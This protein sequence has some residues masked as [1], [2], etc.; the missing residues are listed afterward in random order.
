MDIKNIDNENINKP[1]LED[2]SEKT[3]EIKS[4]PYKKRKY[5]FSVAELK[6]FEILKEVIRDN[7]YIFPK[8]R[9]CDIVNSENKNKYSQFNKIKSKHVDFLVCTKDPIVS[10]MI[11]ELDDSSHNSKS[12]IERDTFIDE[13]FANSR[14]PIVHINVKKF[15]NKK[16]LK[17]EIQ[18]AYKTKYV[19]KE[20]NNSS[21]RESCSFLLIFILLIPFIFLFT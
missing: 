17:K 14:I 20:G 18:D 10:K 2:V 16:L 12:R 15:Y 5:F 9:I 7:Y 21:N 8:V 1:K 13:V 6:F 3:I 11:I 19:F 4:Q